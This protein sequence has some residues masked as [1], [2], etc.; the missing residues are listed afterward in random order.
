M[1]SIFFNKFLRIIL[2]RRLGVFFPFSLV[3]DLPVFFPGDL[4][5]PS[6]TDGNEVMLGALASPFESKFGDYLTD[7]DFP[8]SSTFSIFITALLGSQEAEMWQTP[9]PPLH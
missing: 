7:A 6:F 1:K 5:D 4:V 9:L 2:K 8:T 3:F